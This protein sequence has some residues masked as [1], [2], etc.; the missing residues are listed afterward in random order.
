MSASLDALKQRSTEMFEPLLA[1]EV[2]QLIDA[3]APPAAG[4]GSPVPFSIATLWLADLYYGKLATG[5]FSGLPTVRWNG[6]D[7][8]VY[9]PDMDT[10]F[11]FTT[12]NGRTITPASME[13]DG[14]SIPRILHGLSKFS[15]WGYAPGYMIHDW[16]FVAHKCDTEP[17]NTFTFAESATILAECLK[18][19]MEVGFTNHQGELVKLPKAEDTLYV[20]YKAVKSPIAKKLWD[21]PN[22]VD[23]R[24]PT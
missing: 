6:M 12:S 21:D 14:G 1:A 15:P 8:F 17:D 20:I 10:P 16:L 2:N 22:T 9:L 13:T 3:E 7:Q 5:K 4:F 18:T 19:L 11:S 23:C 24:I